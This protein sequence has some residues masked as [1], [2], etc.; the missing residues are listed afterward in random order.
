MNP[1]GYWA[2]ITA[3]GPVY[4]RDEASRTV[5]LAEFESP[6]LH[7]SARWLAAQAL[8]IAD[9]LDPHPEESPWCPAGALRIVGGAVGAGDVPARLREWAGSAD[10]QR[11]LTARL[12]SGDPFALI[13]SDHTGVYVL[14]LWPVSTRRTPPSPRPRHARPRAPRPAL[15][16]VGS[17]ALA[18][19]GG[20]RRGL[21]STLV[22][23][24]GWA[25]GGHR[26]RRSAPRVRGI[27][28]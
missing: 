10:E 2:E 26:R 19:I 15:R 4:G 28:A 3:E 27:P 8:R 21:T 7:T 18:L 5:V 1:A 25:V 20:A 17:R 16:A 23:V 9:R 6:L 24:V 14:A 22:E 12:A 11:D 13:V